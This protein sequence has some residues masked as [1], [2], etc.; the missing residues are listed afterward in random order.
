MTT[1]E[2]E[3]QAGPD[4]SKSRR[5]P[6]EEVFEA[7]HGPIEAIHY[8]SRQ[9]KKN[10]ANEAHGLLR[11]AKDYDA[12]GLVLPRPFFPFFFRRRWPF[13]GLPP[14]STPPAGIRCSNITVKTPATSRVSR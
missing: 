8:H 14:A 13:F 7:N 2:P 5:V 9:S 1:L 10:D 11:K 12:P 3:C 4:S 6:F